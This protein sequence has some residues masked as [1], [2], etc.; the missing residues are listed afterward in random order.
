MIY[1]ESSNTHTLANALTG[2]ARHFEKDILDFVRT[3]DPELDEERRKLEAG[4]SRASRSNW[5]YFGARQL[6]DQHPDRTR[7]RARR[8]GMETANGIR[9]IPPK[10]TGADSTA[11]VFTIPQ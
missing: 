1:F 5:L 3:N 8:A 11:R 6:F 4:H 9:H 7:L 2:V 10:G